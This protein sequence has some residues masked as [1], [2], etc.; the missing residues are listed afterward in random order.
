M[1]NWFFQGKKVY[2]ATYSFESPNKV[3][4]CMDGCHFY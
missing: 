1:Y 2:K 3:N 4:I